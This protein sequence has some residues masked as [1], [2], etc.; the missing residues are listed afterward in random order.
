MQHH[1]AL[2]SLKYETDK[3]SAATLAHQSVVIT[4]DSALISMP[5]DHDS[6]RAWRGKGKGQA[7]SKTQTQ[8]PEPVLTSQRPSIKVP[9][10]FNDHKS[11]ACADLNHFLSMSANWFV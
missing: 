5:Q 8:D 2:C 4:V 1:E 7:Q 10:P 11:V 3:H 9:E 6:L